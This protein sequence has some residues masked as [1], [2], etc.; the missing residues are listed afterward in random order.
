MIPPTR[1]HA[2]LA[3]RHSVGLTA[4]VLAGFDAAV[5]ATDHDMV[6]WEMVR[7]HARLIVDSRRR[8]GEE[9]GVCP[10]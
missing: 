5:I 8:L 6:D 9:E 2:A 3:G 4:D 7:R 10:A 1:E